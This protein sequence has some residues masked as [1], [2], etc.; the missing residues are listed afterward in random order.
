MITTIISTYR[1]SF[2]IPEEKRTDGSGC[3]I[4]GVLNRSKIET[5]KLKVYIS[6]QHKL[7]RV[8]TQSK[9]QYSYFEL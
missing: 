8:C 3:T 1:D 5:V 6:S 2:C 7:E 9:P 4:T